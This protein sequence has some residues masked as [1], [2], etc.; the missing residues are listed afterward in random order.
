M[1]LIS[2]HRILGSHASIMAPVKLGHYKASIINLCDQYIPPSLPLFMNGRIWQGG[3]SG[4]ELLI[5]G[6]QDHNQGM[7]TGVPPPLFTSS[8]K[9]QHIITN[10]LSV[11]CPFK[12]FIWATMQ[13]RRMVGM[14][15]VVVGGTDSGCVW[16]EGRQPLAGVERSLAD[17]TGSYL[18]TWRGSG[19]FSHN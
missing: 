17:E 5:T 4:R 12:V 14:G 7:W 6:Y 13:R 1:R 18:I 10:I 8:K 9:M 11:H 15:M 19:P 16:S 2:E 3:S